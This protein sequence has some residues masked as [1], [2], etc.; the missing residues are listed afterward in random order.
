M[1]ARRGQQVSGLASATD[2]GEDQ[3]P[4]SGTDAN[5]PV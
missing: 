5:N 3:N 4:D 2:N 1:L